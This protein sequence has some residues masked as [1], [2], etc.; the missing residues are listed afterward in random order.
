MLFLFAVYLFFAVAAI[1]FDL[2][3]LFP[4]RRAQSASLAVPCFLPLVKRMCSWKFF[5]MHNTQF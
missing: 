1:A 2:T 4:A 3:A 5:A